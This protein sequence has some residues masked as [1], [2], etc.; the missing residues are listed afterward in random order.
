M[1]TEP[2]TPGASVT[3][4]TCIRVLVAVDQAVTRAGRVAI[5]S[6]FSAIDVVGVADSYHRTMEL[7]RA[8]HPDVVLLGIPALDTAPLGKLMEN[9]HATGEVASISIVYISTTDDDLLASDALRSGAAG[10]VESNS[11]DGESLVAVIS[12]TARSNAMVVVPA[13][14]LYRRIEWS[15]AESSTEHRK[16]LATLTDR[17]MDVLYYVGRG[18]S[19]KEI[20]AE[21]CISEPTVKKHLS[22][23]LVK[24][25]Q[26][27]RLRAALFIKECRLPSRG[28]G[29]G[30][31]GGT[32]R[33]RHEQKE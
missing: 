24:I 33:S 11:V 23:A 4:R 15:E 28:N 27:N 31:E 30:F 12:L 29:E 18:L 10:Y 32:R 9:L 16:I 19:N 3:A 26:P 22:R 21:L 5:L 7:A 6:S 1:T 13:A 8:Q 14:H 17:E 25:D 2:A 20:A